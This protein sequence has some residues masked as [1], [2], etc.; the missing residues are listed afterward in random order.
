MKQMIKLIAA[1]ICLATML[2]VGIAHAGETKIIK[3]QTI[4]LSA[5][6]YG[7]QKG[8]YFPEE[9]FKKFEFSRSRYELLS[10]RLVLGVTET[11]PYIEV[12]LIG[13]FMDDDYK[14]LE[15]YYLPLSDALGKTIKGR[16]DFKKWNSHNSFSL[17]IGFNTPEFIDVTVLPNGFFK[18][19]FPNQK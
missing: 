16:V 1:D 14:K 5:K 9:E 17:D 13:T 8:P 4:K 10:Y 6:T 12:D 19:D 3:G 7:F 15:T 11:Q 2:L 18:L